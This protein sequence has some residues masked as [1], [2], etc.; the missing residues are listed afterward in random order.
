[1]VLSIEGNENNVL[2]YPYK[3]PRLVDG[4]KSYLVF[5]VWNENTGKL[6]RIRREVPKGVDKKSWVKEKTK[7]ITEILVAGYRIKKIQEENYVEIAIDENISTIQAFEAIIEIRKHE[8]GQTSAAREKSFFKIFSDFLKFC[9][10]QDLALKDLQTNHIQ[11]F[12]DH[13]KTKG[14]SNLT[15]NNYL[16]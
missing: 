16:S 5:Y 4:K 10:W 1:M 11:K 9:G 3:L 15:R 13:I 14:N 8:N 7:A 6:E 12:L 2:G